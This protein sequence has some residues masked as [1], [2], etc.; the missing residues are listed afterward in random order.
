MKRN[1]RD[2]TNQYYSQM[3][4]DY[5]FFELSAKDAVHPKQSIDRLNEVHHREEVLPQQQDQ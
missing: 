4:D 5:Q 2:S 3:I 1:S